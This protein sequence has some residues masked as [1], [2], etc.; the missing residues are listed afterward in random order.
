MNKNKKSQGFGI[1]EVLIS[2]SI[3][4]SV[5]GALVYAGRAAYQNSLYLQEKAEALA[6]AQEGIELTRQ[7]RDTNWIDNDSNTHWNDLVMTGNGVYSEVLPNLGQKYGISQSRLTDGSYRYGLTSGINE[8][9]KVNTDST[10][11]NRQIVIADTGNLLVNSQNEKDKN[12]SDQAIKVTAKVTW[13]NK[14]VSISEI[15]TNWRPNY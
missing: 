12:L 3:I 4:I 15:M 2:S 13:N 6:L 1:I 10:E 9:I 14:E 5:L 11:F 8:K 7:I